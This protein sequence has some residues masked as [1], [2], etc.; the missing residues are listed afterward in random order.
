[1]KKTVKFEISNQVVYTL[2]SIMILILAG[3]AVYAYSTGGPPSYVGHTAEEVEGV[4]WSDGTYCDFDWAS[5][6]NFWVETVDGSGGRSIAYSDDVNAGG[7]CLNDVCKANWP[8]GTLESGKWC[9]GTESAINCQSN[10][11]SE[12]VLIKCPPRKAIV[13]EES[14]NGNEWEEHVRYDSCTRHEDYVRLSNPRYCNGATCYYI[15]Y[16]DLDGCIDYCDEFG[17]TGLSVPYGF[18]SRTSSGFANR[19]SVTKEWET[20]TEDAASAN[21]CDCDYLF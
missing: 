21:N 12:T 11:P 18:I 7:L 5:G 14:T 10:E 13:Y 4:C 1:M 2:L 19:D 8:I 9:T 6:S 17:F 20:Q 15:G 16:S 3:T